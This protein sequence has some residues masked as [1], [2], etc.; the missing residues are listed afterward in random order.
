M[1]GWDRRN[2][3][4]FQMILSLAKHYGFD[5]DTPWNEL[6]EK[7][8]KRV[9]YGSGDEQIAFNYVMENGGKV[10]RKHKLRRHH[11]ESRAPLQGNRIAGRARGDCQ[12]HQPAGLPGMRRPAPQSLG[13][14]C[15]RRRGQPALDHGAAD[16]SDRSS[17]SSS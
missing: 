3:Y 17:I 1:R 15:L 7:I 9:L 5:V 14:P 6:P 13:A 10:T 12:V 11:S 16:R 4:Y 8:R 2:M